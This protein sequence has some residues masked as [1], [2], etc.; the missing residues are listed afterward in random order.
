MG[1]GVG[2]S[3]IGK[4]PHHVVAN[5]A[6]QCGDHMISSWVWGGVGWGWRGVTQCC[7]AE[8]VAIVVTDCGPE[9][10]R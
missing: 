2:L 1:V 8:V 6:L 7:A 10:D 5:A 3:L 9:L 4:R